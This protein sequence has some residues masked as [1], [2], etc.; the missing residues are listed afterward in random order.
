MGCKITSI[1]NSRY[2]IRIPSQ[3][4]DGLVRYPTC[5]SVCERPDGQSDR[6]TVAR[7]SVVTRIRSTVKIVLIWII[8]LVFVGVAPAQDDAVEVTFGWT[9][10]PPSDDDGQALAEAVRYEVFLQKGGAEEELLATVDNDTIYTLAAERGVVQRVR[11]VG[12]DATGRPSPP[13][14][15]SDPIYYEIER[16]SDR[17]VVAP[18]GTAT[19][20]RNYPNPFNPETRIAY[21]VPEGTPQGERAALEIFNLR[22]ER[23]RQFPVDTTPGWHEATWDGR[24]D[25]GRMQ[26]TG[27][28]IA[29]YI[30]GD[31]VQV[32]KM[33]M[34]K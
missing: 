7:G 33:T 12:Y 17:D 11:V 15:W 29:R 32:T 8:L 30:C 34:V 27:T 22:G 21:G 13:S 4:A 3:R 2:G 25:G 20:R 10:C 6:F 9:A 23:I 24:D 31:E 16:S 28:Y 18:P 26:A 19:L 1:D 5:S 14:E